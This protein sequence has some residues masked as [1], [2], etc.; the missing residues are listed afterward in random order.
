M[1]MIDLSGEELLSFQGRTPRPAD[2]DAFW[3]EGLARIEAIAEAPQLQPAQIEV[4]GVSCFHLTYTGVGNAQIYAK[5]LK[6]DVADAQRPILL[7]FH[8]YRR[9]SPSWLNLMQFVCAGFDV[10]AMDC[11]GQGGRSQ[12]VGGVLGNTHSGHFIR[13]LDD[14]DPHRMLMH[15]IMLD[16]A[17]L[18][19]LASRMDGIGNVPVA[20][21]GASQGGG[22]ALASAALFPDMKR[23]VAICPFLCDYRRVW[24]MDLGDTAYAELTDYFR[25]FD[26]RHEREEAIFTKLGYI[27]V[28]HLVPRIRGKVLLMT[29]QMDTTCPP[30]AQYA[31]Y[32]RILA[33]KRGLLY[34]DYGH[35][36]APDMEDMALRFLIPMAGRENGSD[37][38][39]RK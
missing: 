29:G 4:P 23:V 19:R 11:R 24:E 6:A 38:Q 26:P 37:G 3:D 8:G 15:Q 27:D 13:G 35:E 21:F 33:P 1:P 39:E 7:V 18:A 31:A 16:A 9:S 17:R 10:M 14:P 2:F 30:S 25:M 36:V 5:Y 12:D 20:A 32:N 34:P 28:Q 22:L